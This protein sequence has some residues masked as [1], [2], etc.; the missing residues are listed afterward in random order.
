[1]PKTTK[2]R[3]SASPLPNP[4]QEQFAQALAKGVKT[5]DAYVAAGYRKNSGNAG[6]LAASK[7]VVARVAALRRA[8]NGREVIA[9][10][11]VIRTLEM[12]KEI[13]GREFARIGMSNMEDFVR[14]SDGGELVGLDFSKITR[15]Q[16]AAVQEVQIEYHDEAKLRVKKARIRLYQK[17]PAL[18]GLSRLF[19]WITDVS[20]QDPLVERLRQMT[21]EQRVQHALDL[22]ARIDA[23]LSR[24]PR[25]EQPAEITDA[26]FEEVPASDETA[27]PEDGGIGDTGIV[28][29]AQVSE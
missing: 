23:A 11:R 10:N 12:S 14:V 28:D 21:P 6:A 24:T 4:K 3:N 25:E 19:G 26:Q 20:Q 15:D 5:A 16:F 17:T 27:G 7:N 29:G 13:V 9:N 2:Q 1:M 18:I 22:R 8:D